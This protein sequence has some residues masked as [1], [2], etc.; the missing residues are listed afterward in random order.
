[1][2]RIVNRYLWLGGIYLKSMTNWLQY[3][4]YFHYIFWIFLFLNLSA[5][6]TVIPIFPHSFPLICGSVPL[7][8]LNITENGIVINKLRQDN[9]DQSLRCSGDCGL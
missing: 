7:T 2:K 1:M 9:S 8:L 5:I 4:V 6:S 3:L